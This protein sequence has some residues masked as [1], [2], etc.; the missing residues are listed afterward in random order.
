MVLSCSSVDTG[1]MEFMVG[2]VDEGDD[3]DKGKLAMYEDV[4]NVQIYHGLNRMRNDYPSY[5]QVLELDPSKTGCYSFGMGFSVSTK[6]L[7]VVQVFSSYRGETTQQPESHFEVF[8]V[9]ACRQN[10]MGII[11]Y[12]DLYGR[13]LLGE[14]FVPEGNLSRVHGKGWKP[15]NG[16]DGTMKL[17]EI[18]VAFLA[19]YSLGMLFQATGW[20]SVVAVIGNWFGKR[21][22]GLI[23]GVW[24]AHTSIG[25]ISGS[26]LAAS[27]LQYGWGWSF[28]LPDTL[29]F[30]GGIMT[31]IGGEYVS[32]KSAGNL[33][34]LFDVGGIVSGILAGYISDKLSARATTA[35]TFMY[36]VIPAMLLYRVYRRVSKS[37]NIL[38]MLVVGLFVNGPYT[39]ITTAV[40]ADLGTRHSLKGNSRALA[41]VSAIIDGTGSAGAALGHLLT[42][43][44]SSKGW[45]VV[46]AMLCYER[47]ILETLASSSRP[48]WT[49]KD[50]VH[51]N[52]FNFRSIGVDLSFSK[53]DPSI[54]CA[55]L[56]VLDNTSLK[57]VYQDFNIVHLHIPYIP[58]FLTFIEIGNDIDHL[59]AR[60][61]AN[62]GEVKQTKWSV[63][64]I[65]YNKVGIVVDLGSTI[66]RNMIEIVED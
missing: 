30:F 2:S 11:S 65:G 9:G 3:G 53:D 24:N 21:K 16:K 50:W 8:V 59:G 31:A 60:Y 38:H 61:L 22:M 47:V 20:P 42:R 63:G 6:E 35:A 54:A 28:I 45:D 52:L 33:S 46:F 41:T 39:L 7:N 14:V 56:I 58:G 62:I 18:D 36:V 1:D 12:K 66:D 49:Q 13:S 4:D 25:N 34:T 5:F 43:F 29:I 57:V 55:A 19:C 26:L 44:L 37:L 40:S 51:C 23:M 10:T 48:S 17:G 64:E 32:V 15:F 27:V